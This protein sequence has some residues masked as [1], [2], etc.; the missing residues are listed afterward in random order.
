MI[1]KYCGKIHMNLR[2]SGL[3]SS[4]LQSYN[5]LALH[6]DPVTH[7]AQKNWSSKIR[8]HRQEITC[9]SF[10]RCSQRVDKAGRMQ[11][12]SSCRSQRIS[13]YCVP[14]DVA[15]RIYRFQS[16]IVDHGR[17]CP[18]RL[19]SDVVW[20][21]LVSA[22]NPHLQLVV[23]TEFQLDLIYSKHYVT[24]RSRCARRTCASVRAARRR[25][26]TWYGGCA[27]WT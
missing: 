7:L 23:T 8:V 24:V 27:T 20:I 1:N 18:G 12:H 16:C 2:S 22:T 4:V 11:Y 6:D 17:S 26:G 9:L 25:R 5:K 14:Q 21:A 15:L 13:D 19:A 10:R 3:A